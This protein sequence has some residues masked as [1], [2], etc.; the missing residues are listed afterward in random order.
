M[1]NISCVHVKSSVASNLHCVKAEKLM[2]L[3]VGSLVVQLG[4]II[5]FLDAKILFLDVLKIN[6]TTKKMQNI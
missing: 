3:R 5:F 4:V 2:Q 1:W 6:R